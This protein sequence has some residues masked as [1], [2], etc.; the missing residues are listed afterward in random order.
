V[1]DHGK[2]LAEGSP[3]VLKR[4]YGRELLRVVPREAAERERIRARFAERITAERDGELVL[5]SDEIFVERFL[6][7]FG[8]RVLSLSRERPSLESV[9]LTLT[10]RGIRDSGAG[11]REQTR[12]FGRRGG[13]HTG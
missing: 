13:E 3:D 11:P 12:A 6:A 5:A 8:L 2:V 7:E 4:E 1:V 10:G 9:F